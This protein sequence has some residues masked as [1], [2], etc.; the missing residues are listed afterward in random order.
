[1]KYKIIAC[2]NEKLA[3][4]KDGDL[5]Y[6]I[7]ADLKNF[8]RMTTDNVVIM[9]RKTF[10]SLP[11]SEPLKNRVNIIISSNDEFGVDSKFENVFIVHS[12]EEATE[13]CDAYFN[14]K[15]CFVIGGSSIYNSFIEKELID[16][17]FIT[18]VSDDTE[19]DVF[20]PNVFDGFKL[21][22]E[23]SIQRQKPGGFYY[24]FLI[25]KK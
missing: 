9:G 25:Y 16:E 4:G 17:M 10:E 5:L 6:H 20:F 18:K 24:K 7:N 21:F 11:N 23:S 19:G 1:M 12:I 13:L 22:Y 14:D 8:K 2:V 15:I 3:L